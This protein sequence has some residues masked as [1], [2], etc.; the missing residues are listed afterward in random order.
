LL[1]IALLAT[2][3]TFAAWLILFYHEEALINF[4]GAHMRFAGNNSWPLAGWCIFVAAS[5][6]SLHAAVLLFM[7][8]SPDPS[9][10]YQL[11]GHSDA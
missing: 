8:G 2:I 11:I 5:A 9:N 3:A 4:E 6:V 7:S 1:I 10:N